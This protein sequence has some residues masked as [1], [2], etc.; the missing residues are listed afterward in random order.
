MSGS[1][2]HL[3]LHLALGLV[4]GTVLATGAATGA[5]GSEGQPA[6]LPRPS[7]VRL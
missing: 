7:G 2:P 6:Q 1:Y 3:R 4:F 5:W